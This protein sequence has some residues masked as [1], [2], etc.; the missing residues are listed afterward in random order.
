MSV[1]TC[2]TCRTYFAVESAASAC[3]CGELL[4]VQLPAEPVDRA[5]FDRR[6]EQGLGVSPAWRFHELLAPVLAPDELSGLWEGGTPLRSVPALTAWT[7]LQVLGLKMEAANPS[8]HLVDRGVAVAMSVA[9][10]LAAEAVLAVGAGPLGQSVAQ[11]AAAARLPCVILVPAAEASPAAMSHLRA[12]GAHAQAV[13]GAAAAVEALAEAVAQQIGARWIQAGDPW[14]REGLKSLGLELLQD[15]D[16]GGPDWIALPEAEP[17][18]ASAMAKCL[19]E[20]HQLGLIEAVPRL[21]VVGAEPARSG[22][23]LGGRLAESLGTSEPPAGAI[24][25]GALAHK[26]VDLRVAR[27]IEETFGLRVAVGDKERAEAVAAIRALGIGCDRQ[28]AMVI[29]GLRRAVAGGQVDPE[30]RV[31]AVLPGRLRLEEADGLSAV[32]LA[33]P[34]VEGILAALEA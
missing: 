22:R 3:V 7:G 24:R 32:D 8:G 14:Y 5:L 11:Q 31:I 23:G 33:E 21:F 25:L 20:A 27:A 9:K 6:R 16:W 17:G 28:G 10:G 26:A 13:K 4:D 12:L 19:E 15:V 34:S 2:R 1:L 30:D 18:L 29:A